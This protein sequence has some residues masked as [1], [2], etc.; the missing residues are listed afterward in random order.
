M[1]STAK[2][3]EKSVSIGAPACQMARYCWSERNGFQP[4]CRRP[5]VRYSNLCSGRLRVRHPVRH[6][7]FTLLGVGRDRVMVEPLHAG[8][9]SLQEKPSAIPRSTFP[10]RRLVPTTSFASIMELMYQ[11]NFGVSR[12][13][14]SQDR[15]A[16][17]PPFS[18]WAIHQRPPWI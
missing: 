1:Q 6:S 17:G 15:G 13:V 5:T 7:P 3:E 4:P 18:S 10:I 8:V 9:P 11:V 2:L 14:G 16:S 12:R